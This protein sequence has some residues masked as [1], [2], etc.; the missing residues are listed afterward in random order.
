MID[1][2]YP[3]HE[4]EPTTIL[5]LTLRP[6]ALGHIILLHRWQSAFVT[7][8]KVP[9]LD[10]LAIAVLICSVSYEDGSKL[11]QDET[12]GEFLERWVARLTGT[13]SWLVRVGI[14]A[15][16]DIDYGQAM[17]D[18]AQYLQRHWRAPK[19]IYDPGN[20]KEQEC[21][22][23]QMVKVALMREMH[24]SDSEILNRSWLRCLWDYVTLKAI[25]GEVTMHN[26]EDVI[27]GLALAN[28][29]KA[30]LMNGRTPC[31]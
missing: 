23:V 12:L 29:M 21:P 18:F 11:M 28:R 7:P 27:E 9:T 19:V 8:G 25:R 30:Q 16:R 20:F 17:L 3:D 22:E 13:E 24:F 15:P 10:D 1:D 6:L 2:F 5:G 31:P 4:P 26:D 14:R